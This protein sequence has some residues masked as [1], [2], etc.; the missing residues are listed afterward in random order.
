MGEKGANSQG[1]GLKETSGTQLT[2][3]MERQSSNSQAGTMVRMGLRD[4]AVRI[5]PGS[6]GK[7][8]L[9]ILSS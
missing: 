5:Q 7:D 6:V 2:W 4:R 9:L 8:S 3:A 1:Q